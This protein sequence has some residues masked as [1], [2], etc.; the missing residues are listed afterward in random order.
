MAGAIGPAPDMRRR[1]CMEGGRGEQPCAC[2]YVQEAHHQRG[3]D[4]TAGPSA[5]IQLLQ[6]ALLG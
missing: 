2:L 6:A 1:A 5:A 4:T 3:A